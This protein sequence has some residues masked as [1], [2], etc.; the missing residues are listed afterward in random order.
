[1]CGA[2]V[3]I[4]P[5]ERSP[6][7]GR[8]AGGGVP[9]PPHDVFHPVLQLQLSFLYP[10]FLELFGFGEVVLGFELMKSIVELTVDGGKITELGV[11]LEKVL[12]QL[13]RF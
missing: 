1:V 11:G 9:V 5:P 13:R 12:L 2:T 3:Q 7:A 6:L 4:A 10:D 8:A